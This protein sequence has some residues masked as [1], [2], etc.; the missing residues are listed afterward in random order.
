MYTVY[1]D[2]IFTLWRALLWYIDLRLRELRE[3]FLFAPLQKTFTS[4]PRS[5]CRVGGRCCEHRTTRHHPS[6]PRALRD[7]RPHFACGPWLLAPALCRVVCCGVCLCAPPLAPPSS[8]SAVGAVSCWGVCCV[9]CL[10]RCLC[11]PPL[12]PPSSRSAVGAPVVSFVSRFSVSVAPAAVLRGRP[13][14][15]CALAA[16]AC[17]LRAPQPPSNCAGQPPAP[18]AKYPVKPTQLRTKLRTKLRPSYGPVK[19]TR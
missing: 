11:A 7:W 3:I 9:V 8:R 14:R 6:F 15:P 19:P 5:R 10:L 4:V 2:K 17:L 18:S 16:S 1:A 13:W 12:A